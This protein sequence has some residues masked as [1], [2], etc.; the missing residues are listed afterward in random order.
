MNTSVD[1]TDG[2]VVGFEPSLGRNART[3]TWQELARGTFRESTR[4][5]HEG[6][7]HDAARLVEVSL[8]EAQEL[9]EIYQEWPHTVSRWLVDEGVDH[10]DLRREQDRLARQLDRLADHGI[11]DDWPA[12]VA[13]VGHAAEACRAG[14]GDA[15]QLVESARSTWQAMHDAAVDWV[16]GTISIAVDLLGEHRLVDLWD[17]LLVD[18]YAAH[19]RRYSLDHQDWD[20]SS[21][22][23]AIAIVD[24]FHAH[25][26]GTARQGDIEIIEEPDRIG[27]RFAP[28]GSGG[29]SLDPRITD[30]KPLAAE[31]LAFAVTTEP[32]DWAWNKVGV[33]SYCVHCCL[34]NEVMPI[35]RLGFPTR[36]IDAPT[37]PQSLEDAKC[38]WW[39]YR[40]PSLVPDE[41][42]Q[43]V[44]RSPAGRPAKPEEA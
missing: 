35:D 37:W 28:C 18:W 31:P 9:R 27:F 30:G 4:M 22:Q 25:L 29:R 42:Y 14:R 1:V 38:T 8:L 2:P 24:G 20:V 43:R 7:W 32:H 34:L 33:C 16:S 23:L 36:V 44:G 3:G 5:L 13:A 40:H 39:I 15:E 26:A 41:V 10:A 11:E 21:Q 17:L 6:R 12:Y 19:E